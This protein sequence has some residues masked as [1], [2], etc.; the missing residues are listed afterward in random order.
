MTQPTRAACVLGYP[1]KHSKSPKL[2]GYWL[3]KYGI[4]GD[5]RIEEL[6]PEEFDAFVTNL[7]GHG[8][9]GANVTMPHK[10]AAFRLSEP[11]EK[12]R[13][14]GAVNTLWLDGDV[15]RSTSTDGDGY[16]ASVDAAAPGWSDGLKD[17]VVL[18]AGGASRSIVYA[19]LERGIERVHVVNRTRTKA[20]SMR[21]TYGDGVVPAGWDDVPS[22]L[23]RAGLLVNTTSLGMH[24]QGPLE[25]DLSP[26]PE[27][28]V[29]SDI[30]YVPLKTAL[31]A[32]AEARGLRTSDGL[33]MLLHQAVKGF[34]LWFGRHPDVTAEQYDLM[35][36][37][38]PR[39]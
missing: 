21:E 3:K 12:G 10:Q 35:S 15:L 30:V 16:V 37:G 2:H 26:L 36:E 29:V 39:E 33:A 8:Y 32:A 23:P 28:A 18:G 13:A 4:D 14:I 22:L 24:G 1:A 5:Y 6:P 31:L 9:V 27:T 19:L 17:A 11:D 25:I 38:I 7:A 34:E 20:E